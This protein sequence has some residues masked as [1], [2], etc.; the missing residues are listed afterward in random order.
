[1][2][3]KNGLDLFNA[4]ATAGKTVYDIAQG[5]SKH[6]TKKQLNDVYDTLMNL[7][8]QEAALEDENRELREELRF[9]GEGFEFKSPFWYHRTTPNRPLCPKCFSKDISAPMGEPGQGC[10]IDYRRCL[11]CGEFLQVN[12]RNRGF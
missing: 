6:E 1:M 8:Q 10:N 12:F 4:I 11:V 3:A 9:K 7:K 5:V 2:D